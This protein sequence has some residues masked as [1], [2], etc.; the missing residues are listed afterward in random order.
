V[1]IGT[2]TS[3]SASYGK[4]ADIWILVASSCRT[5]AEHPRNYAYDFDQNHIHKPYSHRGNDPCL[6]SL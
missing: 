5:M 6:S 1:Y 4:L 2:F 3:Y